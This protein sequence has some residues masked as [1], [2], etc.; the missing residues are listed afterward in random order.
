MKQ[1]FLDYMSSYPL[2]KT[3]TFTIFNKYQQ[4][5]NLT[6]NYAKL[7]N[8]DEKEINCLG[9]LSLSIIKLKWEQDIHSKLQSEEDLVD[10]Q[11]EVYFS[12]N[13]SGILVLENV[14]LST[15]NT[16]MADKKEK[17]ILS[18][19]NSV[20]RGQKEESILSTIIN[21]INTLYKGCNDLI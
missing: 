11:I 1:V 15:E 8:L 10:K 2:R 9:S 21:T 7:N 5:F 4:N 16:V 17:F 14:E 6:V 19:E 18:S 12:M 13:S 20:K 3:L